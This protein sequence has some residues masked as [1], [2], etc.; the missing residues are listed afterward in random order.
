MRNEKEMMELIL[1]T[2]QDDKRIRAVL[3][4]G[5]RVNPKVK[6]DFFQDCLAV[7]RNVKP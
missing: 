6:K 4:T 1:K 2:A 7:N 3:M 5:S